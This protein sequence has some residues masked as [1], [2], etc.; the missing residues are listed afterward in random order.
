MH[1]SPNLQHIAQ[2]TQEAASKCKDQRWQL[3]FQTVSVVSMAVLG[4][5]TAVHLLRQMLHHPHH[6]RRAPEQAEHESHGH[7]RWQ[8][9]A[10]HKNSEAEEGHS[11][12][13]HVRR[14]G[15][16]GHHRE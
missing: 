2:Q 15:T 10:A 9:R 13:H 6:K 11:H 4:V 8:E 12:R 14:S 1:P 3:A 7:R 16:H 5:G